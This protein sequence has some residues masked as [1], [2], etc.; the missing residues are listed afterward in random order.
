MNIRYQIASARRFCAR[1][2]ICYCSLSLLVSGCSLEQ[3]IHNGFKVGP[4]YEGP[5]PAII[6]TKW[7]GDEDSQLIPY[8]PAHPEWW[9]ELND[10]ILNNLIQGAYEQNLSLREAGW[11]IMQARSRLAITAGNIFPQTQQGFAEF[12]RI[13]ESRNVALPTPIRS[14]DQRSAGFNLS[15]ELDVW[16]RF[17]RSIDSADAELEASVDDY[18]AILICLI[19]DVAAAYVDYRTFQ[20]RLEYARNNV[21]IQENSLRLTQEKADAGKTGYAGVHMSKSSLESTRASIPSLQIGL[22]QASNQ[23]CTLLGIETQDLT[24][25]LS[26]GDIP[27][28][29]AEVAIGIPVDLLRRRPDIRASERAIA[30]QSEQIGIATSDLYPH[31]SINGEIALES[32]NITDLFKTSSSAGSISPALQWNLLNYGRII[33]NVELQ[34]YGLEELI[35][36]YQSTVLTANQEVEDAL[37][38]YLK[39]QQRVNFLELAT[40]ETEQALNLLTI[41]FEEG[42]ISFTGV[43]VLQGQLT[44]RQDEYAAARGDVLI[45]LINLYKALGGGW[46]IRASDE[47]N[48]DES[49]QFDSV[50]EAIPLPPL[51][52]SKIF[53]APPIE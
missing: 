49:I 52:E 6:A 18:D 3:W 10:P 47:I 53:P 5:P 45:S 25:F 19:A 33:N 11:R 23:L 42:D 44:A 41:A 48:L 8:P 7:I 12:D 32:K 16:G 34:G 26:V 40:R 22:Q 4:N 37:V 2:L 39:N 24:E 15:W 29:P 1:S 50:Q 27:K 14:F 31:F 28:P 30:A 36:S 35:T 46:E 13:L 43:F 20:L 38:A 21:K 51:P 17:R 9:S